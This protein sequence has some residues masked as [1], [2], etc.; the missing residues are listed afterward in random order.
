MMRKLIA[1][2]P[3]AGLALP[4]PLPLALSLALPLVGCV[5]PPSPA[6]TVSIPPGVYGVYLDNDTGAINFTSW[7][8]A[9]PANTRGNPIEAVRAVL[10]LEYLAVELGGN[11]RWVRVDSLVDNRVKLARDDIRRVVGIRADAPPQFVLNALLAV[12]SAL[13][14]GDQAAIDQALSAPVFLRPPAETLQTLTDLPYD[15][16]ANL[17]TARVAQQALYDGGPAR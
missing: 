1:L 11:P 5:T 14:T 9:S 2:L 10:G 7:A 13:Q 15:Q 12:S 6:N 4:L 16:M 17:A 8:F 3:A